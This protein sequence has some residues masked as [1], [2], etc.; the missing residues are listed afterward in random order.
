MEVEGEATTS[1]RL[2]LSVGDARRIEIR[3]SKSDQVLLNALFSH[4][5]GTKDTT[6]QSLPQKLSSLRP[7]QAAVIALADPRCTKAITLG[8]STCTHLLDPNSFSKVDFDVFSHNYSPPLTEAA[9]SQARKK[10][11]HDELSVGA[12]RETTTLEN[13]LGGATHCGAIFIRGYKASKSSTGWSIILPPGWVMPIWVALAFQGCRAAGQREWRWL[14]TLD[15]RAFFPN[16]APD[17]SLSVRY[18]RER[19]DKLEKES[20]K[21][22]IGKLGKLCPFEKDWEV[23]LSSDEIKYQWRKK[24]YVARTESSMLQSLFGFSL[25][26]QSP[27]LAG[28]TSTAPHRLCGGGGGTSLR[29][30]AKAL[31]AKKLQWVPRTLPKHEDN[32]CL[33]ETAVT[34]L[35]QGAIDEDAEIYVVRNEEAHFSQAQPCYVYHKHDRYK[36]TPGD[37]GDKRLIEMSN[38]ACI[39]HITSSA[40][41]ATGRGTASIGLVGAAAFWRLRSLQFSEYR[42]DG[43]TVKAWLRN[44]GSP[45]IYPVR[46]S[47]LV[48]KK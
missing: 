37:E 46:L 24:T 10:A 1:S 14:H 11:R 12:G 30:V 40:P 17:S 33:V 36:H 16:D 31:A 19:I 42:R 47:L 5:Q 2:S 26:D 23:V 32:I 8:S 29:P 41:Q 34:I 20:A 7:S 45:I 18:R 4:T 35:N 39:G 15:H 28:V 38:L 48:E 13:D 21:R 22:P 3:G 6:K 25:S 43:G 9:I 27:E 44:T